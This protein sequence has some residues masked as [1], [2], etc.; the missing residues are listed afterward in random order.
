MLHPVQAA[1]GKKY[2]VVDDHPRTR[3][4][5][6]EA[7]GRLG[8]T[9]HEAASGEDAVR[10]YE[11]T[12]PDWVIMDIR[13]PGLDGLAATRR[14]VARH[15]EARIL[16]VSQFDDEE[17]MRQADAAGARGFLSKDAIADLRSV[18]EQM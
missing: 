7:L 17:M 3:D 18:L 2:L 11:L 6:I 8:D 14:I 13:M 12:L 4:A 15:P 5:L 1:G 10:L 16:L 9:F